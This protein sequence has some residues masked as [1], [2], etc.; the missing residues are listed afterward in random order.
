MSYPLQF[1]AGGEPILTL[2]HPS[3]SLWVIELHNGDDSRLTQLLIE[4]CLKPALDIVERHWR[5]DRRKAIAAKDKEGGKGALIIVGNTKQD[6]F[7]SNGLDFASISSDS[8]FF[9][10][11]F[12][13]LL[14][15][16]LLFPI[17]TIAAI[18]GHC[19]AGGMMLTL[20]CD[21]RVMTDGSKKNAWMSM[22]E[23]HFGA[24]WPHS[25]ASLFRAKVASAQ[26]QRKIALEGYRFTPP[27]A[28]DAG[29]VDHLVQGNTAAVLKAAQELADRVAPLAKTG[30]FGLI[31]TDLYRNAVENMERQLRYVNAE[32]DD[33]AAKARL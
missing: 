8:N 13:P 31:K 29:L 2:T 32:I 23:V 16:I 6:K 22:N 24:P 10:N 26:L 15:R 21:Y 20:A 9:A 1:P 18:N 5:E 30:V 17:P 4:K 12:D 28:R 19:F 27:E 25:F 7:F 14:K 11:V 3:S 33:A